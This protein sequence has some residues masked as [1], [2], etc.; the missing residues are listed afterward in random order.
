MNDCALLLWNHK[1][2]EV[3]LCNILKE[4]LCKFT[5]LEYVE[6]AGHVS[7]ECQ[8]STVY[9]ILWFYVFYGLCAIVVNSYRVLGKYY[10]FDKYFTYT[11]SFNLH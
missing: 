4:K 1:V 10:A 3:L 8:G 6:V 11:K 7:S 5:N 9:V 2:S